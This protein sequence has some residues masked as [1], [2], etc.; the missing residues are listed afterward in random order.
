MYIIAKYNYKENTNVVF[1]LKILLSLLLLRSFRNK[2]IFNIVSCREEHLHCTEAGRK[3]KAQKSD[4]C[5]NCNIRYG[6]NNNISLET[7][8]KVGLYY[9]LFLIE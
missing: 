9:L 4:L 6:E 8:T 5:M 2:T 1:L 7:L 3:L